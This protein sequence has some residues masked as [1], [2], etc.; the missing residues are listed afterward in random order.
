MKEP[1]AVPARAGVRLRAYILGLLC[2][3]GVCVLVGYG[4]LVASRGGSI[5]AVLLGATHLPPGAMAGLFVLL[6][7]NALLRRFAPRLR[8]TPAEVIAIYFM[9]VCAAL[10]SSFGLMS[11]LLPALVAPNY[12]AT[13]TN[14]WREVFYRHIPSWLL[15]W[16]PAGPEMQD[17]SRGFYEGLRHGEPIPWKLWLAPL[18]AWTILALLLFFLMACIATLLRRQWVDNERLSFPLVQLPVELASAERKP[19]LRSRAMWLGFSLPFALH[20]LNGLH[21]NFPQVPYIPVLY[22]LNQYAVT[23]P[24]TQLHWTSVVVALSV[25]GVSYLLPLD[26]SFS[27]WFFLLFFRAQDVVAGA[28]GFPPRDIPL[29][30][31]RFHIGYQSAGAFFV[32]ALSTLWLARPHLRTV[33]R[34]ISGRLQEDVDADEMMGYRAAFVGMVVS[35]ALIVA[36]CSAAGIKPAVAALMMLVFVFVIMVVLSRC[37]AEVGLLFL[38]PIFRPMDVWALGA[39][40]AALGPASL[41]VLAFVNAGFFRD[42]RNV[43]PEFFQ[44]LKAADLVGA[45]RRSVALAVALA[46]FAGVVA[47]GLIHLSIIYR[48]G[49]IS[50]NSWFFVHNPRMY[51]NEA[52]SILK[53]GRPFDPS[54]GLWFGVGAAATTFLYV[55]RTRFWWWPF[56]PLG[57]AMGAAWPAM[58]YWSAF[59]TGWAAKALILRYGGAK[60]YARG[61]PFF[62]GLILGEFA[63]ALFWSAL[64][65]LFGVRAP[66][67]PIS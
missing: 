65:A 59:L 35:F 10:V 9:M 3:V 40:P 21:N 5:D 60:T 8:L 25:V 20:L 53:G 38:Q 44:S 30:P 55:M 28:L 27:F 43:M 17:V 33:A 13:P 64:V 22:N 7:G 67:I 50:L 12:F 42:P 24:W 36:W 6:F 66:S 31:A 32:V 56:H 19:F 23:L 46:V 47:A 16:D 49:G 4:E 61:R 37:V 11:V 54:A 29:Y 26:V 15:P 41:T 51:F 48:Y 62:L 1:D 14:G 63:A 39:P 2:V 18:A 57:Y 34:R 45:R 58:V 52:D